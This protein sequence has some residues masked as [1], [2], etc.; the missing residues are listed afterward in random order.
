MC[1]VFTEEEVKL[2]LLNLLT[3]YISLLGSRVKNFL[4]SLP[5]LKRLSFALMQML[6]LDVT[7]LRIVE[8][9]TTITGHGNY[10]TMFTSLST[11]MNE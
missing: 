9:R 3:G 10:L 8:E 5:H 11:G 1:C 6:E 2:S 4:L 7:D